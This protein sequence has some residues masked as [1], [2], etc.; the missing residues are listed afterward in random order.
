MTFERPVWGAG[1]FSVR[2]QRIMTLVQESLENQLILMGEIAWYGGFTPWWQSEVVRINED[3]LGKLDK[4]RE[5]HVEVKAN[6]KHDQVVN[7]L[8]ERQHLPSFSYE[9]TLLISLLLDD[10]LSDEQIVKLFE[11]S[12]FWL[13]RNKGT[14]LSFQILSICKIFAIG[15]NFQKIFDFSWRDFF[16]C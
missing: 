8:L 13:L 7:L 15:R 9:W 11:R 1:I 5:G 6:L 4:A 12:W 16:L 2:R 3:F 14:Y 10:T